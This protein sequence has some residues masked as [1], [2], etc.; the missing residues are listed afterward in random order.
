[1][2]GRGVNSPVPSLRVIKN[3]G[4]TVYYLSLHMQI[5]TFAHVNYWMKTY[6][7]VVIHLR[8]IL[9]ISWVKTNNKVFWAYVNK[10]IKIIDN[11]TDLSKRGDPSKKDFTKTAKERV[12]VL[13]ISLTV[14]LS[15]KERKTSWFFNF[16]SFFTL[17]LSSFIYLFLDVTEIT[18]CKIHI[19]MPGR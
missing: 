17:S 15:V 11:I 14:L 6:P 8:R 10:K 2:G 3:H 1:M 12:E 19:R 5:L 7:K 18:N 4:R 9:R 16:F 13:V